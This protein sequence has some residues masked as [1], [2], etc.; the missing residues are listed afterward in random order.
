MER[1]RVLQIVNYMDRGGLETMLMNYYRNLDIEKIQFDFLVHSQKIAD[2]DEEIES[3]GGKIYRMPRLNP[4]SLKYHREE[5]DFFATHPYSI[6]HCHMDCMSA[7]PLSHAKKAGIAIRIAHSHNKNQNRDLKYPIKMVCKRLIPRYATHLFACGREAGRFMFGKHNFSVMKNAININ[8]YVFDYAER[9]KARIELGVENNIVLGNVAN[10]TPAKNHSFLLDIFLEY[11]N[12]NSHSKLLLVGDGPDRKMIE[13]KIRKLGLQDAVI[14]TGVRE[15]VNRLL[16]AMDVFVFPSLYEGLPVTM[17]E[18]QTAGLPCVISENVPQETDITELVT[19][20]SLKAPLQEWVY[21]IESA[22]QVK[23]ENQ[24]N[25]IKES[26]FD[27]KENA[28]K[29]EEFYLKVYE[30]CTKN[31]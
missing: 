13:E 2:Y 10:F 8:D 30:Q 6:V 27:I 29:L 1:L 24:G 4:V 16:Q 31:C 20:V 22:R 26:G 25:K 28:K 17:I 18:A 5:T 3:M 14:L 21:K 12:I 19:R 15:D 11:H 7:F 23:R 9:K